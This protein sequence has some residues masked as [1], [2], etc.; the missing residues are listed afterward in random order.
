MALGIGV[1]FALAIAIPLS[2]TGVFWV[3]KQPWLIQAHGAA[4]LQ[5]WAGLFV[6]GMGLRLLPRFAGR[7]PVGKGVAVTIFALLVSGVLVRTTVPVA[8]DGE[9]ASAGLLTGN[10]LWAAGALAFAVIV[11]TVLVRGRGRGQSWHAFAA[12]G[13][14][15]W[16]AWAVGGVDA[17]VQGGDGD[18]IVPGGLDD[19]IAWAAMLGA[20]GNFIWAVQSRSVPIFYGR[21]VPSLAKIAVPAMLLNAGVVL[22]FATGWL[23]DRTAIARLGGVGLLAAGI[24]MAWI[25][26]VAG[27]CWGTPQ[28]LRPRARAAARFVLV[29]N[30]AAVACGLLMAWAGA[31]TL[32]ED[33][34]A[35]AGARDAARHAFGVGVITM[36]IVGMAQLLAPFF[37]MQRADRGSAWLQEHGIFW[38][39]ALATLIRMSA[40]LLRGTIDSDIR[41]HINAT[42]GV[43]AWLA[44][45]SFAYVVARAVR[46]EPRVKAAIARAASGEAGSADD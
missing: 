9:L 28:R 43:L 20:I 3:A 31:Q 8:V 26:P 37:A 32:A 39:L 2:A 45:V 23:D 5:G 1:G 38:L 18:A 4:Q 46:G 16:A 40:G 44:L 24:G 35:G 17:A 10:L 36:L 6:A 30:I 41:M 42:S 15:W 19:A 22:I 29:A 14:G 33:G 27:S 11:A 13:V 34:F 25:A 7:R 21:K 12:A